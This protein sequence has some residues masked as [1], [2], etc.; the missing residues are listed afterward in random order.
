MILIIIYKNKRLNGGENSCFTEK[1]L[2]ED[3]D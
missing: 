3:S 2:K 1:D